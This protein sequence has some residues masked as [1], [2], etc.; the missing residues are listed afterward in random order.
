[1]EDREVMQGRI[2]NGP[3]DGIQSKGKANVAF[4]GVW[5]PAS[6]PE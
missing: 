2:V 5:I 6:W 3:K 4:L 1:M